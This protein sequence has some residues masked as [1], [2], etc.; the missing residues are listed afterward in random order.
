MP[1]QPY[2]MRGKRNREGS[3]CWCIQFGIVT[4]NVDQ[5]KPTRSSEQI[6]SD[7]RLLN[8]REIDEK[9][10]IAADIKGRADIRRDENKRPATGNWSATLLGGRSVSNRDVLPVQKLIDDLLAMEVDWRCRGYFQDD[11]RKNLRIVAGPRLF[12]TRVKAENS[13]TAGCGHLCFRC[14][15]DIFHTG[16]E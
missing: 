7:L 2:V 3:R 11:P 5:E 8:S 4:H 9:D 16:L 13:Q 10:V 15:A 1:S 6:D 12:Q 14:I